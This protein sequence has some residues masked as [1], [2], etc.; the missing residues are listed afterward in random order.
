MKLKRLEAGA[1][2]NMESVKRILSKMFLMNMGQS[3]RV[4][5][6]NLF[7][8]IRRVPV[9]Q[10]SYSWLLE[11][12]YVHEFRGEGL[13]IFEHKRPLITELTELGRALLDKLNGCLVSNSMV[14]PPVAYEVDKELFAK[15]AVMAVMS[16][17]T[18]PKDL[19]TSILEK[20]VAELDP[21]LFAAAKKNRP[22]LFQ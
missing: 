4:N 17:N 20:A 9:W 8:T 22:D 14:L 5:R 11:L 18:T 7:H 15:V 19:L 12:K 1:Q 10:E 21:V 6:R 13:E 16:E 2:P 3:G